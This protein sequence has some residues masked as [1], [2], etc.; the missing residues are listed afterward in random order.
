MPCINAPNIGLA[1][2][3]ISLPTIAVPPIQLPGFTACCSVQLPPIPTAVLNQVIAAAI[4]LVSGLGKILGP[5]LSVLN[6]YITL[7]NT[8]LDTLTFR[9]PLNG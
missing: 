8:L 9:C 5:V 7:I 6:A 4:S 1:S 3:G 2:L